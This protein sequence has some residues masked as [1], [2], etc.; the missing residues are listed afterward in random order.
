ME[1]IKQIDRLRNEYDKTEL[2][3]TLRSDEQKIECLNKLKYDG[4]KVDVIMSFHIN[5]NKIKAL[6][7]LESEFYKSVVIKKLGF[8]TNEKCGGHI[9][10]G[11][12]FLQ[13][14]DMK[15]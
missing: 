14:I 13:T 12:D 7:Q 8:S 5:K 4:S 15:V 3:K 10:I 11:A 2:I 9:H 1:K 6:E